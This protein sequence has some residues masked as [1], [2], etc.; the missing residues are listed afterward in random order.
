MQISSQ[1]T[2]KPLKGLL[3]KRRKDKGKLMINVELLMIN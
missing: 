2:P 1:S 3:G